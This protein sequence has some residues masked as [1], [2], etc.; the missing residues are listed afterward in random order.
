MY[1]VRALNS[2]FTIFILVK[3]CLACSQD[4]QSTSL[5]SSPPPGWAVRANQV[6]ILTKCVY[7]HSP[8][9]IWSRFI[10]CSAVHI[11]DQINL[12]CGS[13][14][15]PLTMF[16][17]ILDLYSLDAC[18]SPNYIKSVSPGSR[19]WLRWLGSG[20]GMQPALGSQLGK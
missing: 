16:S 13:C 9:F 19:G 5:V 2:S 7:Q 6:S 10:H 11:L 14:T 20:P 12:C 3:K 1:K 4:L 8:Q 15:V 17:G 18:G